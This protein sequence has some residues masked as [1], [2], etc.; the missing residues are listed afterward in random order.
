MSKIPLNAAVSVCCL[1]FSAAATS[2]DENPK[3]ARVPVKILATG[4]TIA[5]AGEASGYGYKAGSFKVE[6]LIKAVPKIGELA[7][8]SGEQVAN[9]GSQD[10]N[11]QVWLK[12]AQRTNELL[13]SKGVSG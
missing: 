6:D 10:M 7:V 12:L 9:I 8:L 13:D 1:L 2:A 4:G 11:D 5:G 3:S